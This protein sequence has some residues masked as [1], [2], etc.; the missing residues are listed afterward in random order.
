MEAV[1]NVACGSLP[2]ANKRI[3][4]VYMVPLRCQNSCSCCWRVLIGR[5][6]QVTQKYVTNLWHQKPAARFCQTRFSLLRCEELAVICLLDLV[7]SHEGHPIAQCPAVFPLSLSCPASSAL[8]SLFLVYRTVLCLCN[9]SGNPNVL[10]CFA[11]R[12]Y[13][14]LLTRLREKQHQPA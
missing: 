11:E 7:T 9:T 10:S 2:S 6:H 12:S 5:N 13:F 8:L 14:S 4:F 3:S 1:L